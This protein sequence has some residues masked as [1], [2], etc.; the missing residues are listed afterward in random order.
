MEDEAEG[1]NGEKEGRETRGAKQ[2]HEEE[3]TKGDEETNSLCLG[4][5]GRGTTARVGDR[6][7]SVHVCKRGNDILKP[8]ECSTEEHV[9]PLIL[10]ES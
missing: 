4:S 1:Q 5:H 6:N 10:R 8:T 2:N 9:A 7:Q 3:E